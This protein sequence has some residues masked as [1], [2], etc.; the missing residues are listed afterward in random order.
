[1]DSATLQAAADGKNR[2]SCDRVLQEQTVSGT[3][4]GNDNFVRLLSPVQTI[5]ERRKTN[6]RSASRKSVIDEVTAKDIRLQSTSRNVPKERKVTVPSRNS[7][8]TSLTAANSQSTTEVNSLWR[9]SVTEPRSP[10]DPLRREKALAHPK[11][12]DMVVKEDSGSATPLPRRPEIGWKSN[13]SKAPLSQNPKVVRMRG[14]R[15]AKKAMRLRDSV[16]PKDNSAFRTTVEPSLEKVRSSNDHNTY[17]SDHVLAEPSRFAPEDHVYMP[18][19]PGSDNSV[20]VSQ[21]DNGL[22]SSTLP[23]DART[24]DIREQLLLEATI[25]PFQEGPGLAVSASLPVQR[26]SVSQMNSMD[27]SIDKTMDEPSGSFQDWFTGCGLIW[28]PSTQNEQSPDLSQSIWSLGEDRWAE[29]TPL[30]EDSTIHNLLPSQN[31]RNSHVPLIET[32]LPNPL[33]CPAESCTSRSLT[34]PSRKS[35]NSVC[36]AREQL[37]MNGLSDPKFPTS[38]PFTSETESLEERNEVSMK[39][40]ETKRIRFTMSN[41][42]IVS[43]E[44]RADPR[45]TFTPALEMS[46]ITPEECRQWS[47]L[48]FMK[49]VRSWLASSIAKGKNHGDFAVKQQRRIFQLLNNATLVDP[50]DTTAALFV[51]P[52]EAAEWLQPNKFYPGPIFTRN[53]QPVPLVSVQRFLDEQYDDDVKVHV[54]DPSVKVAKN[55]PHVR[56][57]TL[58]AVKERFA[59]GVTDKPW[60]CLELATHFEDGLRPHFLNTEDCRLLTKL[61]FPS[62]GDSASRNGYYPGWKEIEKWALLAQSGAL[63]EPHQDSH[64][65]NTYITINEGIVGYGWLSN[66]TPQERAHWNAC[67]DTFINGT[68]HYAILRPGQTV[69]FP[70]GT[71]HFVFRLPAAGPTLAFGG[72]VLRCSQIVQW[73][74]TILDE[75]RLPNITNEDLTVSAPAYLDRVEKFVRQALRAGLQQ[76]VKWGGKDA[77]EEFLALK[78]E[79]D[80]IAKARLLKKSRKRR[81]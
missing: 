28:P 7:R 39:G 62:S 70:S 23:A 35:R 37:T 33:F 12:M 29:T 47:D 76:C 27:S 17:A 36:G 18:F 58:R 56:Q 14:Q 54:Q 57:V 78:K 30:L 80:E 16:C 52:Q 11:T 68:W 50:T 79:F 3:G 9:S 59:Q 8:P 81:R 21:R 13:A 1:M 4:N 74:R 69:Y 5:A 64:G 63:T 72:H 15:A 48:R 51:E 73:M 6:P 31:T 53:A 77:I 24:Q 67:H 2:M 42:P 60:N 40:C 10:E 71:V 49:Y 43:T 44:V 45:L 55:S 61:K 41:I 38:A 75:Q 20:Q 26:V 65:Y 32:F 46:S 22:S 34:C 25:A 66:P 19:Y